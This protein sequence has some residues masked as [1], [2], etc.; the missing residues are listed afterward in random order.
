MDKD[1][2]HR[3]GTFGYLPTEIRRQIWEIVLEDHLSQA[4][5]DVFYH[6][7]VMIPCPVIMMGHC[8]DTPAG[9]LR[10]RPALVVSRGSAD[11]KAFQINFFDRGLIPCSASMFPLYSLSST[12]RDECDAMVFS[13]HLHFECLVQLHAFLREV[14]PFQRACIRHISVNMFTA[15]KC[16]FSNDREATKLWLKT[17]GLIPAHL[18][19]LTI[20]FGGKHEVP[21]TAKDL[22]EIQRGSLTVA[23]FEPTLK[24]KSV[25]NK[26]WMLEKFLDRVREQ[27]P[28]VKLIM[29]EWRFEP[30]YRHLFKAK[31]GTGSSG[32]PTPP[33]T[34]VA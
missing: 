31:F 10:K 28:D 14:S 6:V 5:A 15:C 11:H 18:R 25:H 33:I 16:C 26:L 19:T 29:G 24:Y 34:E 21:M 27:A 20:G 7:S 12:I 17:F 13:A 2:R 23:P 8:E 4:E 30:R 1:H 9:W 32:S 3:L 22:Y